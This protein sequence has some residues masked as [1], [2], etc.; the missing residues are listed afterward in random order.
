MVGSLLVFKA[1]HKTWHPTPYSGFHCMSIMEMDTTV[2]RVTNSEPNLSEFRKI[3]LQLL[4]K[5]I[6]GF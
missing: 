1:Q 2:G 4:I 3:L 5:L 6:E